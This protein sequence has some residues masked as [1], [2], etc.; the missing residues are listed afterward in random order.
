VEET[1][2]DLV[3][4]MATGK[5]TDQPDKPDQVWR[6]RMCFPKI[7]KDILLFLCLMGGKN[8]VALLDSNERRVS[9]AEAIEIALSIIGPDLFDNSAQTSNSGM[10][11]ESI[12]SGSVIISSHLD[13]F[14]GTATG[15]V[16]QNV[17]YELG[18]SFALDKDISYPSE[19][20]HLMKLI[21]PFLSPV[22]QKWPSYL[23]VEGFNF[24]NFERKPNK[25]QFDFGV[26]NGFLTGECKDHQNPVDLSTMQEILTRVPI[27][28]KVHLVV[29][30][31][32]Q[33]SYFKAK[34]GSRAYKQLV[35][36]SPHL[37]K[38]AIYRFVFDEKD[39]SFSLVAIAGLKRKNNKG[40]AERVIIFIPLKELP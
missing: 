29:T 10:K 6:S 40:P 23:E 9:F 22:N 14:A 33:R 25:D 30:N 8:H 21:V 36:Q 5:L 34:K 18:C 26:E 11:L 31:W 4:N 2:F 12:V 3:L 24:A 27:G 19:I 20:Q 15:R 39:K 32:I 28:S 17:L 35:R 1:P 7:E 13:G 16:I 38:A 37:E